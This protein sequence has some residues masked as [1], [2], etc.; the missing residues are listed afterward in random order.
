[1][2]KVKQPPADRFTKMPIVNLAAAGIDVGSRSHFVAIGQEKED[3]K[4]RKSVV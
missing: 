4:D 2:K 1:M 3:V